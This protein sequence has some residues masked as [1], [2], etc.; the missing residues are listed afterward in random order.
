M[1]G[2][3]HSPSQQGLCGDT[4]AV[5]GTSPPHDAQGWAVLPVLWGAT[6]AE[7]AQQQPQVEQDA[8]PARGHL[9]PERRPAA[10]CE[11]GLQHCALV[12]A[13]RGQP[14]IPGRYWLCVGCSITCSWQVPPAPAAAC[15]WPCPACSGDPNP[16]NLSPSCGSTSCFW[17]RLCR[18]VSAGLSSTWPGQRHWSALV[19]STWWL[20]PHTEQVRPG[21]VTEQGHPA[22][23]AT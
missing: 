17:Q 10:M 14:L 5:W 13:R 12:A 20:Q 22:V 1:H 3:K 16:I 18:P 2:A 23:G 9:H 11:G 19:T 21:W 15:L 6:E 4:D 7:R 8:G